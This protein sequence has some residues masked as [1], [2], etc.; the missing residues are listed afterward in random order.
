MFLLCQRAAF[1][2]TLPI[3]LKMFRRYWKAIKQLLGHLTVNTNKYNT[4]HKH[5]IKKIIVRELYSEVLP[6]KR[7]ALDC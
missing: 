6:Q 5:P 3:S 7:L 1:P 4:K 2:A